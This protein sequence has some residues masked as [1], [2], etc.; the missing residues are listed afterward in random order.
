MNPLGEEFSAMRTSVMPGL[1]DSLSR[2]QR[3][4]ATTVKLFEVGTVF[5][6][7]PEVNPMKTRR[8]S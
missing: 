8:T 3:Q 6:Q 1:L 5:F 7:K 4:Q 2:N